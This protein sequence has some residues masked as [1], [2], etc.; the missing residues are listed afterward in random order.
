MGRGS[1]FG[2]I[3]RLPSGRYRA[4]YVGP[5]GRRR[6]KIFG[7]VKADARAWLA[8]QQTDMI[9][10]GWRAPEVGRRTVGAY[11]ADYLA[12][13]DLRDGTRALYASLWRHHLAT[14]WGQVPVDEVTPTVV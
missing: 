7:A 12:R 10:K 8:A 11:A 1:G 4:R 3:D 2:A 14:T 13:R 9:R 5:D 6:S